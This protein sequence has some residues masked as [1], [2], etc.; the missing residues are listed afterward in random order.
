MCLRR[1][2]SCAGHM[3]Q[4]YRRGQPP[5]DFSVVLHSGEEHFLM[6]DRVSYRKETYNCFQRAQKLRDCDGQALYLA[7]RVD[8]SLIHI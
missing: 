6:A 7:D 3:Q 4:R 1:R 5:N 2:P 8:L